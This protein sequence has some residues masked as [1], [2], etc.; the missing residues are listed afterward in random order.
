MA[1]VDDWQPVQPQPPAAPKDDWQAPPNLSEP[2]DREI[3]NQTG[4]MGRIWDAFKGGV[5]EGW[6]STPLGMSDDDY[7]RMQDLGIFRKQ[8]NE[9]ASGVFRAFNELLFYRG[10]QVL[11]GAMRYSTATFRGAQATVSQIGEEL[12]HPQLGREIAAMPEAFLGSP[13][14]TGVPGRL[15]ETPITPRTLTEARDLGIV[16]PPKTPEPTFTDSPTELAERAV[17]SNLSAAAVPPNEAEAIR[18]HAPGEYDAR[19]KEWIDKIDEPQDVRD[20]IEKIANENDFFPEARGG[21][22][23]PAARD[24]VAE[25]A[26]VA[27]SEIDQSYFSTHFDSDGKVRAVIQVL[28]QTGKDYEAASRAAVEKPTPENLAA[29]AEAQLRANHAV[30]YTLGLRAESG[31]TLAAWKD[32]LRQTEETRA[33]VALRSQEPKPAKPGEEPS[34]GSVPKG[35]ADLVDAVGDVRENLKTPDKKP[36]LQKLVDAARNLVDNADKPPSPEKPNTPPSPEVQSLV[37]EARNVLKK[38]GG[39]KDAELE[40]F[41]DQLT[42]LTA[43]EGK[44]SDTVDAARALVEKDKKPTSKVEAEPKVVSAKAQLKAAAKRLVDAA[45]NAQPVSKARVSELQPLMDTARQAVGRLRGMNVSKEVE[46]FRSALGSNDPAAAAA[47]ARDLIAAEGKSK[48]PISQKA[49][50]EYDQIMSAARRV[51]SASEPKSIKEAA[52]VMPDVKALLDD[53]RGA[54]NELQGQRKSALD[55]LVEAAEKQAVDMTKQKLV[56]EPAEALPPELQALVDKTKRVVDRFGGVARGERAALLLARTGRTFEEQEQLARS[57]QGLTPNQVAKVLTKLRTSPDVSRPGWFY[58]LWQQGL[59]SGLV[60]HS[61][62]LAVNTATTFLERVVS[63]FFGAVL[64]RARGQNTSIAGPLYANVAMVHALPD[65]VAAA[66]QA[67]KT[68]IR[69]PLESEMR[70]FERGEESPQTKGASGAYTQS[71][72]PDWGI[73]HRVFNETQLDKAAQVLGIPGKSANMI[74]TFYKVLSER[75]S[76]STTAFQAAHEE[77]VSGDAFWQRYRYH[78]DNPTDDALRSSVNDAYTGAFMAKLGPKMTTFAHALSKNPVTKWLFP[79]QHI[80]WNIERMSVEYS[81][82]AVL[83]PEMRSALLGNKGVPAQDLAIAKM[84]VGSSVIGYFL[85]KVLAGQATGDYPTDQQERHKWEM[86]GIR[87]NSIQIGGNWVSYE[88]LGPIGN[89]AHMGASI[90]Q[91]IHNYNGQDDTA[92]TSALWASSVAAANQVGNEVG[93]QSLRNLIDSLENEKRADR[94]AAW[95]AGSLMP[96]SSFVTQD[97]SLIDPYQRK[98]NTI[99]DGLKYRVPFLRETLLPKRDPMFGEPLPNPSYHTVTPISPVATDPIKLE[100]A[101]LNIF[102]TAPE[103]RIG[104]VKLTPQLQ[105]HYEA[106]AGPLTKAALQSLIDMPDWYSLPAYQRHEMFQRTIK[107]TRKAAE[108]QM[109]ITYPQLLEAGVQQKLDQINGPPG[110]RPKRPPASLEGLQ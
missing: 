110:A 6:G 108:G 14:P 17:P 36:G 43:G 95:Q 99:L 73:W 48:S 80:P 22:A 60:T 61:K 67:F 77:G 55:R 72:S 57:V 15:P 25:A 13:N 37:G 5:D 35:T 38:F 29:A 88:R 68:G 9:G 62:Y 53:A 92:L 27:P 97:A 42:R 83:G 31:R 12:G 90:G 86:L 49:P 106:I 104:G 93:F 24:A 18:G 82:F 102:P 3:V 40:A 16:G 44:L 39:E 50:V 26:G 21:V 64:D 2:V 100:A 10:A 101:R 28:R 84:V 105:D 89:V 54:V 66:A 56:K 19:G 91:I 69:V 109:Q 75:A 81:P 51:A 76:A 96:M 34:A 41:R 7:K 65:A 47:A 11:D 103:D 58:W 4:F 23:S 59:I 30:E 8:Q 78:L 46:G 52:E 32:L 107:A 63:P 74:H 1:E 94:F 79:F 45:D 71:P 20:V 98:A 85:H 70:L 33:K 87:P